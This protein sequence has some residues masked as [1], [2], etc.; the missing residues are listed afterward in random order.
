MP[1]GHAGGQI[2]GRF[3]I[4]Q[5]G[6]VILLPCGGLTASMSNQSE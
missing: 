5:A 2:D 6:V 4:A 1:I 3:G